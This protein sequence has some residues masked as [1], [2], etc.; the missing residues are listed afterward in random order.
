MDGRPAV[1]IPSRSGSRSRMSLEVLHA[2]LHGFHYCERR[3]VLFNPVLEHQFRPWQ[4]LR[5]YVGSRVGLRLAL[6]VYPAGDHAEFD[7][8]WGPG[9]PAFTGGARV[10]LFL[11][12]RILIQPEMKMAILPFFRVTVSPGLL[13]LALQRMGL[14]DSR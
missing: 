13:L 1:D 12:E 14:S 8:D 5:P 9:F 6:S 11:T 4:R 2:E 3:Q 10:R 7:S